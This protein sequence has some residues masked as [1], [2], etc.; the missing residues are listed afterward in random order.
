M[1]KVL[2]KAFKIVGNVPDDPRLESRARREPTVP[3][4]ERYRAP[5]LSNEPSS[6]AVTGQSYAPIRSLQRRGTARSIEDT[7]MLTLGGDTQ[8]DS[9]YAPSRIPSYRTYRYA[10]GAPGENTSR[11]AY[12]FTP[13]SITQMPG[14][15][16]LYGSDSS[17]SG[18][19]KKR[20][21]ER[22]SPKAVYSH[23]VFDKAHNS[24]TE[25]KSWPG[26]DEA[27]QADSLRR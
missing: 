4:H 11:Q 24:T 23:G 18:F 27:T 25:I 19:T 26:A 15:A 16:T 17:A 9:R 5:G 10:P 14:A 20:L 1:G 22:L 3:R 12:P 6:N 21:D 2:W 8:I 7:E 13:S